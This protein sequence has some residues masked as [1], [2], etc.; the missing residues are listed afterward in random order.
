MEAD[1]T[2][3][4]AI[5][6]VGALKQFLKDVPDDYEVILSKDGEG[7]V[8]SPLSGGISFGHYIDETAYR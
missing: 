4:I 1:M 3:N 5:V 8:F 2:T 7:N 6:T